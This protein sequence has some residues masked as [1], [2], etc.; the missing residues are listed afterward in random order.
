MV[1]NLRKT[2]N[3]CFKE[4]RGD[5][6]KKHMKKHERGNEY[7]FITKGL[8]DGKTED[9]V[10]TMGLHDGKTE[11]NIGTNEE[12]ISCNSERFMGL[13]KILHAKNK[14]FNRKI[15][16]GREVNKIV[17]KH[18]VNETSLSINNKEAL[19]TY[20]LHGKNMDM[21]EIEW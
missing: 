4:M 6:L 13:E 7:N 10:V 17:N 3:V 12:Q 8:H 11:D 5:K 2:C 16:L 1:R 9:N 19:K 18:G 14:E 20:E 21:K 15:E